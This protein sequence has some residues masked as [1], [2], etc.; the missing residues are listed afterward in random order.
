[1][2][3]IHHHIQITMNYIKNKY[4]ISNLEPNQNYTLY[5]RIR[6]QDEMLSGVGDGK[7]YI[8]DLIRKSNNRK[9]DHVYAYPEDE[10][11]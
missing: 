10:N 11:G 4:N 3:H 8:V 5:F 9:I 2:T 7:E 6:S 1:M